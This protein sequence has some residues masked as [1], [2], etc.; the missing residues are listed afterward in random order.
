MREG[1]FGGARVSD[2]GQGD[3]GLSVTPA[4]LARLLEGNQRRILGALRE[5]RGAGGIYG[6]V[7]KTA[8][9]ALIRATAEGHVQPDP[10]DAT[11]LVCLPDRAWAEL[12]DPRG[13][14]ESWENAAAALRKALSTR[15]PAPWSFPATDTDPGA[16]RA[17]RVIEGGVYRST[18]GVSGRP[19]ASGERG[20]GGYAQVGVW[21]RVL[22]GDQPVP[23]D[24][25]DPRAAR[26]PL[27][28]KLAAARRSIT[29]SREAYDA[30]C[31]ALT[32]FRLLGRHREA[33]AVIGVLEAQGL[34]S[35]AQRVRRNV[36]AQYSAMSQTA[37]MV[38]LLLL[39]GGTAVAGY[40]LV[41]SLVGWLHRDPQRQ[42]QPVSGRP[43][44][45]HLI[46]TRPIDQP[47]L[48]G[49]IE[50][51][52]DGSQRAR[53][54]FT[55]TRLLRAASDS[56]IVWRWWI[57]EGG[58]V[59]TG[60]T[61]APETAHTYHDPY[62][63]GTCDVDIEFVEYHEARN[64]PIGQRTDGLLTE[65][66]PITGRPVGSPVP[67]I[68]VTT[69]TEQGQ[70]RR[71]YQGSRDDVVDGL[72]ALRVTHSDGINPGGC[73]AGLPDSPPNRPRI[74]LLSCPTADVRFTVGVMAAARDSIGRRV[75]VDFGDGS[76]ATGIP[77]AP[78]GN[79]WEA[80]LV[81]EVMRM[82]ATPHAYSQGVYTVS[83]WS[84]RGS[85][86]RLIV[87]EEITVPLEARPAPGRTPS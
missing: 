28:D 31:A 8:V 50:V 47:R 14:R 33:D 36:A 77:P 19:P 22:E 79:T 12:R 81:P 70:I 54:I 82:H 43:A 55:P 25:L 4:A 87:R 63:P 35:F 7:T 32:R 27:E 61:A 38:L 76:S 20:E 72:L 5:G 86:R 67:Q 66:D 57:R 1:R 73:W 78:L 39:L 45:M 58:V 51:W 23:V 85:E 52:S 74:I 29:W 44:G 2:N 15:K 49:T 60:L 34:E 13:T 37:K 42:G 68:D 6:Y 26:N 40:Y 30:L 16:R 24:G 84:V 56:N 59:T 69:E 3:E 62:D 71:T 21:L 83:A 53:L 10:A 18:D 11:L 80:F 17:Q 64:P 9:S 65:L 48:A 46:D 75:D 41:K